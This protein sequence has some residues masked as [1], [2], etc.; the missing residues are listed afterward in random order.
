MH[1]LAGLAVGSAVTIL[2]V[3]NL[4]NSPE[5]LVLCL[6]AWSGL[7]VY[8]AV[9]DR[10]PRATLFQMAGFASTVISFPFVNDPSDIF[11]TTIDRVEEAALAIL[12]TVAVHTLLRPWD[13]E[14]A[15]RSGR[16]RSCATPAAGPGKCWAIDPTG[17]KTTC[18]ASLPAM[19]RNWA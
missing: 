13:T 8:L 7:C 4:Q 5:L 16:P 3:P 15:L 11:D 19:S 10:S 9:L 18:A 14:A 2:L 6:A 1:R 17:W 12:C